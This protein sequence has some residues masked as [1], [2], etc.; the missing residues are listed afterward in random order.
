MKKAKMIWIF[1]LAFLLST[2]SV[3]AENNDNDLQ[4]I[5]KAV[6]KNGRRI[7]AG[8]AKWLKVLVT[9]VKS[10]KDKVRI[11]LPLSL[12][13]LFIRHD[14]PGCHFNREDYDLDLKEIFAELKELG[15]MVMIEI[16]EDDEIVKVWL[17]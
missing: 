13:E 12:L 15:P 8:E 10:T 2:G 6:K 14:S 17:E 16:L 5:K 11:T 4:V 1:G 3:L 7:E 9:D